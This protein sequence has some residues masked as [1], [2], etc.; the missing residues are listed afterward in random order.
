MTLIIGKRADSWRA[1][2]S[3]IVGLQLAISSGM[4]VDFGG[5]DG[6]DYSERKRNLEEA[7]LTIVP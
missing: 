3:H 1:Q 2:A 4:K 7:S 6:W 5:L